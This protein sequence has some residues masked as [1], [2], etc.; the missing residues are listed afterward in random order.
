MADL[1]NKAWV[2]IAIDT[3]LSGMEIDVKDEENLAPELIDTHIVDCLEFYESN[4]KFDK[5]LLNQFKEDFEGWTANLFKIANK[6]IRR[7][8]KD[9]LK[10]SG[11]YV[12]GRGQVPDQ[13]Y[14]LLKCDECPPWPKDELESHM[15]KGYNFETRCYNPNFDG[16]YEFILG[17]RQSDTSQPTPIPK[18]EPS[19]ENVS[20]S[21]PGPPL[22][23]T[24]PIINYPPNQ[25]SESIQP[26]NYYSQASMTTSTA[27]LLTD[28]GK[29]YVDSDNK[30]GG[31]FYDVLDTKLRI[32][33]DM[34]D[35]AGVTPDLYGSAYS[36]MLKDKAQNFYYQHLARQNLSFDE[37]IEKT[38][39]YFHTSENYQAYL[40]E[41][42]ST[43]LKSTI[44][45][46]PERNISECLEMVIV[47][48]QKIH[49]GLV[50][51]YKDSHSLP[52]QL[53]SAC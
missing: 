39:S 46:N 23:Q 31:S 17:N 52:D 22:Q 42:R 6:N 35:K 30:F 19:T 1:R 45:A 4:N 38:R 29:L 12:G 49:Q 32:F 50:Q 41:W 24:R 9:R 28:L 16:Q 3:K 2:A 26:N 25:R 33:Y 27:R 14:Y 43:M 47:K 20:V 40:M 36:T 44:E 10:N 21:K 53:I 18:Q 51:N 8:L 5:A 34:C 48:L 11:V 15:Q 13:L 37:M 7:E